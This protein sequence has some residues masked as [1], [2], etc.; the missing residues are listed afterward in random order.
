M[1]RSPSTKCAKRVN[2]ALTLIKKYESFAKASEVLATQYGI[3]KR[4][5]YRYVQ[6]AR[7]IGEKVPIPDP[8]LAFTVKLSKRLIQ[9]IRHY[10]K[11]T[12][13]SISEIVTESL[14][15]FLHKDRGSGKKEQK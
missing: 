11:S 14:E 9:A 6:E 15:V 2:S 4:Q 12:G 7:I 13:K 1:K 5:A 10:A 8:K 3:S